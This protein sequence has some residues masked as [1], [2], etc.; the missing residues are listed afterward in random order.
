MKYACVSICKCKSTVD[1]TTCILVILVYCSDVLGLWSFWNFLLFCYLSNAWSKTRDFPDTISTANP[2]TAIYFA[3]FAV[4]SWV[5]RTISFSVHPQHGIY[6]WKIRLVRFYNVAGHFCILLVPK[7]S[8]GRGPSICVIF[9]SRSVW[10]IRR[11]TKQ[12]QQRISV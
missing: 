4:F 7:I 12:Q 1:S 9:R 5:C 2:I 8:N 3:L 11:N 10:S 6:T